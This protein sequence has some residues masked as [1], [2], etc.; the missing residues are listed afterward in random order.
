MRHC[1]RQ[2][3]GAHRMR[4]LFSTVS[5]VGIAVG[6]ALLAA[7]A[8]AE[9]PERK[10]P[11]ADAPAVRH[12]VELRKYRFEVG[13]GITSTIGQDF[14]HGVLV[15]G[16][17]SF[18]LTDWL[19]IGGMGAYNVLSDLETSFHG[20]LNEVL[21]AT[22]NARTPSKEEAERGMNKI[23]Y[24]LA[25]QVEFIPMSGK[26]SLFSRLFANYDLYVFGGPGFVNFKGDTSQC[27]TANAS[28]PV[29]G[30]KMGA[31]FGLGFRTY[32]NNWFSANIE[33]R[34]I[35]LSNNPSGRD[36]SGDRIA[37]DDDKSLDSNYMIGLNFTFLLPPTARIGD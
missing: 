4:T 29:T 31:N 5:A 11:L 9:L 8:H 1:F 12:R 17:A 14:Y 22:P 37:D 15:G 32:I 3:S 30:T 2:R 33:A 13:P 21:P 23:N 7:P 20:K 18:F 35:L 36:V 27:A 10:S 28:C 6:F 24:V 19:A 34:D 26:Y 16:K 25:L